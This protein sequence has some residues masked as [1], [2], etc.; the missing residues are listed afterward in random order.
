[1]DNEP[2]HGF[3]DVFLKVV[4]EQIQSLKSHICYTEMCHFSVHLSALGC[5]IHRWVFKAP[6]VLKVQIHSNREKVLYQLS[7]D[8][9]CS[10]SG[11]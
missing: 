4:E 2:S 10:A 3:S 7:S 6:V 9:V 1:M 8:E 5:A 11:E